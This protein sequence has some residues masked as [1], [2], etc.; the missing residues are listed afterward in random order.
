[1]FNSGVIANISILLLIILIIVGILV[2]IIVS[3]IKVSNEIKLINI[4]IK[5]TRGKERRH[6]KRKKRKLLL[7]ALL[8]FK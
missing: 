2:T 7:S 6:Y 5:R 1:M 3:W 8:F 4:E